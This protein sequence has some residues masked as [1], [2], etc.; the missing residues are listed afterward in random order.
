METPRVIFVD[1]ESCFQQGLQ[2]SLKTV[3]G[4][5]P[6]FKAEF[7]SHPEE[8]LAAIRANPF[9]VFLVFMD[10]HF[11]EGSEKVTLGADFIKPIKRINSYIE[12]VMMSAEIGRAHV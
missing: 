11:R 5:E 3:F 7:Y 10:H 1:D 12:I 6:S 9:N 4:P 2:L 8:A